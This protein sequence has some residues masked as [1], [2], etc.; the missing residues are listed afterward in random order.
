[1]PQPPSDK[2]PPLETVAP[3]PAAQGPIAATGGNPQ[4]EMQT[5][6]T[7]GAVNQPGGLV[8]QVFGD[9]EL[10]EELGRGGM[11]VVYK[12]IQRSLGRPVAVKLLLNE[13]ISNPV[14]LTRFMAEA[15][16]AA[17]LTHPNVISIY[18][19]SECPVGPYFVMEFIDG[20]SLEA[21]LNR[22]LPIPWVVALTT[23]VAEAVQHAHDKGI[24]HRDLKPGNILLHQQKRPVVTDFGIAKIL[25][26]GAASLTRPGSLIGTPSYMPPE[27]AGDEPSKIGPHSDVYSLGAI[28]YTLLGGRVPFDEGTAMKTILRVISDAPPAPLRSLRA[29]VPAALEQIVMKCL[30]KQPSA[31]YASA[32]AL[33]ND[34]K[35]FRAGGRRPESL[36]LEHVAAI[37]VADGDPG[38]RG[39]QEGAPVQPQHHRRPGSG[40]RPGREGVG[41]VEA[42]LRHQD[43]QTGGH[44]R[45][46]GQRQRHLRQRAAAGAGRGGRPRGRRQVGPGR[47]R[48]HGA[49]VEAVGE[50]TP[51]SG[52]ARDGP[53]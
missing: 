11:G 1:M 20:P 39:R 2:T 21:F 12:A 23:T 49:P 9:F 16:A 13:F 32:Q 33:A 52:A 5:I 4:S 25:G 38:R 6:I 41:G 30:Q 35:R 28:A 43:H 46:P 26:S 48:V 24:I 45:G 36:G 53:C 7:G 3:L 47:A 18:Q 22:T 42:S 29:D 44:G 15:R 31:R 10:T 34:L 8:G 50:M 51:G 14:M 37:D 17:S 19:I 40:L 27:Q